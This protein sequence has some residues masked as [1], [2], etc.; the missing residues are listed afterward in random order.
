MTI[1]AAVVVFVVSC[2]ACLGCQHSNPAPVRQSGPPPALSQ[3]VP[4]PMGTQAVQGQPSLGTSAVQGQQGQLV[5]TALGA[6]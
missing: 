5:P 3:N 1:R 6:H 2:A 4:S